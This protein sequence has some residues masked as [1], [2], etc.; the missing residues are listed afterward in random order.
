MGRKGIKIWILRT[1]AFASLAHSIDGA[2]ALIYNNEP[3]LLKILPL[4]GEYLTQMPTNLYL[5]TSAIITLATWGLTCIVAYN[6]PSEACLN[7]KTAKARAQMETEQQVGGEHDNFLTIAYETE[8]ESRE[9]L[10]QAND[11]VLNLR[12]ELADLKE[13]VNKLEEKMISPL[14]CKACERPLRADFDICPYCGLKINIRREAVVYEPNFLRAEEE[15]P[16]SC[17]HWFGYLSQNKKKEPIQQECV[18]CKK[19]VECILKQYYN[20]KAAVAEIRKWY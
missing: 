17:Q 8:G 7:K 5:C 18:E 19:A 20:S 11:P 9:E 15:Q 1:V 10:G 6:G 3:Q 16:K 12:A 13:K 4:I 2:I 14:L